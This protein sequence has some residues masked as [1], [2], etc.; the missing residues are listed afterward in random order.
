MY[1]RDMLS[2]AYMCEADLLVRNPDLITKYQYQTNYLGVP[3]PQTDDWCLKTKKRFYH[4]DVARRDRLLSYVRHFLL[5][6]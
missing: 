5:E 1:V 3:V 2:N 4:T 6:Y